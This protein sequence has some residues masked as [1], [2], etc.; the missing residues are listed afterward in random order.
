MNTSLMSEVWLAVGM[1]IL[2]T[3]LFGLAPYL[4]SLFPHWFTR[5]VG[6]SVTV[7]ALCTLWLLTENWLLI[8]VLGGC[9]LLV[10][11]VVHLVQRRRD[12]AGLDETPAPADIDPSERSQN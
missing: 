2:G 7:L 5:L 6:F 8:A 11:I 1:T 10:M 9:C 12:D 4:P 3:A